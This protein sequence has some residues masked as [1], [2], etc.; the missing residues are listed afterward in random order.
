MKTVL[1]MFL[2]GI[3]VPLMSPQNVEITE[4]RIKVTFTNLDEFNDLVKVKLDLADVGISI[5]YKKLVFN[6]FGNLI[7]IGFEVDCNDGFK[8]SASTSRLSTQDNFGFI[9]DY[10]SHVPFTTGD[11]SQHE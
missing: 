11:L 3:V 2:L 5:K 10:E 1:I 9:R 4:E 8:G 7:E 6:G